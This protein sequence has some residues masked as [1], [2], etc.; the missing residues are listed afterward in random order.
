MISGHDPEVIALDLQS[1]FYTNDQ[2]VTDVFL[3][4]LQSY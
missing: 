2:F 3:A 4:M 1:S